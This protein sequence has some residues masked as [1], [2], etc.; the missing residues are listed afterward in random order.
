MCKFLFLSFII[1]LSSSCLLESKIIAVIHERQGSA[2][3]GLVATF[4]FSAPDE[5]HGNS[6]STFRF[7]LT[8]ETGQALFSTNSI[9]QS[10]SATASC[11]SF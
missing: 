5:F 7:P 2:S 11:A 4:S 9:S 1:V 3:Q 6:L 10:S 8:R